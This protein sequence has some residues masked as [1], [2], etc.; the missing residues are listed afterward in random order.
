MKNSSVGEISTESLSLTKTKDYIVC[1][2][3]KM[4]TPS[5]SIEIGNLQIIKGNKIT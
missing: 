5:L 3:V 1:T 2:L 4:T